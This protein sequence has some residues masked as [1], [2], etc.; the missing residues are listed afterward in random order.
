MTAVLRDAYGLPLTTESRAAVDHYDRGVRALLGFGAEAIDDFRQAVAADPELVLAAAG[1]A[2]SLYLDEQIPAARAAMERARALGTAQAATLTD[3]ERRHL[4]A[5]ELFVGGRSN[6]AIALMKTAF[7]ELSAGRTAS[8]LRTVVQVDPAVPDTLM[9]SMPGSVPAL[10]ALGL[11]VVS[12][13]PSNPSRGLPTIRAL[14]CIVDPVTGE[15]LAIMDGTYLTALRTGAVS[16]AAT[17][18]MARDDSHVVAVIGAGAQG[19]TQVAA[20]CAVRPIERIIA[21]F[22][23]PF[24][25]FIGCIAHHIRG[26]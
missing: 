26:V 22:R 18:L 15:P 10:S 2:V 13:V 20:V 16:G 7:S 25:R 5:L 19:V 23:H 24:R 8:P 21:C 1:L 17:D 9:L 11:K 4:E 6:D 14:V 3:R 12:V